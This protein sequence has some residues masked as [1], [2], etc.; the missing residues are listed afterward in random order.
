MQ[1][2]VAT[3]G[4]DFSLTLNFAE[5]GVAVDITGWTITLS[6]K[7][8]REQSA[9]DDSFA[10]DLSDPVNGEAQVAM[11]PAETAALDGT[12]FYDVHYDDGTT[13]KTV[14]GGVITFARAGGGS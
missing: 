12:Y 7:R 5:S 1:N 9:A 14:M 4:D 10:A 11:T 13:E 3:K 6:L 2:F 8:R